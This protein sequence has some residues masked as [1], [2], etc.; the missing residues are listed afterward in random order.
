MTMT[1]QTFESF[2]EWCM[3]VQEFDVH[4]YNEEESTIVIEDLWNTPGMNVCELMISAYDSG[5]HFGPMDADMYNGSLLI[6]DRD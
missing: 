2:V 3:E 6:H 1:F 5:F 4:S